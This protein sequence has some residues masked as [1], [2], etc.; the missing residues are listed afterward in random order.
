MCHLAT[1][2]LLRYVFVST[3]HFKVFPSVES[4]LFRAEV[5][6]NSKL[7]RD[8]KR[9]IDDGKL[10]QDDLVIEMVR[11][12]LDTPECA[13]GFLLDG[14]PRTVAQAEKLQT[15]LRQRQEPLDA[16]VEFAIDDALLVR[17]ICGRWF[18]LPSGR[19]Y[20]E[21]F[22][23]PKIAGIDDI[24]GEPLI[25]RADDNPDT[26]KKR[27]KA[28][29]DQTEPLVEFYAK[30]G[31]HRRIDASQSTEPVFEKIKNIFDGAKKFRDGLE[32]EKTR[33]AASS[34]L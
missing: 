6:K 30:V 15:L 1:G 34:R 24:T 9:V 27:L 20:H 32:N 33:S 19:S 25:R 2:D 4:F 16:V 29:H 10:V 12:K 7:G 8:I 22:R 14:F 28:Y 18:H 26:L 23:P 17:R 21:E 31:L 13:N 5:A 11:Q 3:L